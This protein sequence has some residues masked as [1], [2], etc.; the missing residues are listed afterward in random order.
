AAPGSERRGAGASLQV[1]LRSRG[2]RVRHLR[3]HVSA[4]GAGLGPRPKTHASL[5]KGPG[6]PDPELARAPPCVSDA[7][8]HPT[9]PGEV[10]AGGCP[11]AGQGQRS[12]LGPRRRPDRRGRG[13]DRRASRDYAAGNGV[14]SWPAPA[15]PRR[16]RGRSSWT[17]VSWSERQVAEFVQC[18]G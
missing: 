11:E 4:G 9:T 2:G 14:V 15:V 3:R 13:R 18:G 10:G 8:S 6:G 7:P 1:L 17:P 5:S 12:A 16:P